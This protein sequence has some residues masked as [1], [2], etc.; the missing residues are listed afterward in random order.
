MNQLSEQKGTRRR[1]GVGSWTMSVFSD[2][3]HPPS[4]AAAHLGYFI[5]EGGGP[6]PT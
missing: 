6:R 5:R 1:S 3:E 4:I 2:L